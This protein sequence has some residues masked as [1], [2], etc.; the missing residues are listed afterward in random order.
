MREQAQ[1]TYLLKGYNI[2]FVISKEIVEKHNGE[3]WAESKHGKGITF[4]FT[5]P[6]MEKGK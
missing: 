1:L 3:I 6:V 5:L 2:K 4:Y